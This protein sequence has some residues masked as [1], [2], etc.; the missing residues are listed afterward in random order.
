MNLSASE[1]KF[2]LPPSHFDFFKDFCKELKRTL[3]NELVIEVRLNPLFELASKS[4]GHRSF[5]KLKSDC[6]KIEPPVEFE[7]DQFFWRLAQSL[8]ELLPKSGVTEREIFRCLITAQDKVRT[9]YPDIPEYDESQLKSDLHKLDEIFGVEEQHNHFYEFFIAFC[10]AVYKHH[11]QKYTLPDLEGTRYKSFCS[12]TDYKDINHIQ[13][14]TH[15]DINFPRL[16]HDLKN[17]LYIELKAD[18][19][20]TIAALAL[21]RLQL[22][23]QYLVISYFRLPPEYY[24]NDESEVEEYGFE[25]LHA[26][27]EY[28]NDFLRDENIVCD[29]EHL[30]RNDASPLDVAQVLNSFSNSDLQRL[31]FD[32]ESEDS[33]CRLLDANKSISRRILKLGLLQVY[34]FIASEIHDKGYMTGTERYKWIIKLRSLGVLPPPKPTIRAPKSPRLIEMEKMLARQEELSRTAPRPDYSGPINNP[35]LTITG[36]PSRKS[37][38][39]ELYLQLRC[40][41]EKSGRVDRTR[42]IVGSITMYGL[43]HSFKTTVSG[44]ELLITWDSNGPMCPFTARSITGLLAKSIIPKKTRITLGCGKKYEYVVENVRRA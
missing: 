32:F 25:E 12:F 3:E 4:L 14:D 41:F 35:S 11:P 38:Y 17:G 33:L 30:W 28:E 27:S 34:G 19:N 43:S 29:L 36:K 22:S 15:S 21:A 31:I 42:K 37:G 26:L 18:K 8:P 10:D 20:K 40:K 6:G 13:N 2:Y 23:A 9:Q 16:Y 7:W 24:I 44:E 1:N 39:S 5:K